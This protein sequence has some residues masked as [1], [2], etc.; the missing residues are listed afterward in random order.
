MGHDDTST[1]NSYRP[2]Y[3]G[4]R[5]LD[6]IVRNEMITTDQVMQ[7]ILGACPSFKQDWEASDNH[8][9]LYVVMGDLARH[10]LELQRSGQ[11]KELKALAETIESMHLE[12]TDDVKTLATIGLLEGIQ[13]IWRNNDCDPEIFAGYLLPESR[14]CWDNLNAF[15][16]GRSAHQH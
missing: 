11:T 6:V 8:E 7:N 15:W 13:N 14:K 1:R 4:P 2:R 10:L 9:L 12:G 3:P 5:P 16:N